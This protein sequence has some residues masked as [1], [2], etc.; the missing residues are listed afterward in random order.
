MAMR[1]DPIW[2]HVTAISGLDDG[3]DDP[4]GELLLVRNGLRG[5]RPP[6]M[7]MFG[8]CLHAGSPE[9]VE[10]RSA[11]TRPPRNGVQPA[12]PLSRLL[13]GNR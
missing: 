13:M 8:Y 6:G 7:M 10:Q 9:V 1:A 5:F 12:E 3:I 2:L 11:G 4:P